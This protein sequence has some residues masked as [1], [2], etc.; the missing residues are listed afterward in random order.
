MRLEI[1]FCFSSAVRYIYIGLGICCMLGFL[2]SFRNTLIGVL[3]KVHTPRLLK[4][5]CVYVRA[6]NWVTI[7]AFKAT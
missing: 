4:L 3:F 5:F 6:D 7:V 2:S 1:S